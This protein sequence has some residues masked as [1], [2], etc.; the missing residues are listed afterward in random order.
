MHVQHRD[1]AQAAAVQD[2]GAQGEGFAADLGVLL[3][4]LVADGEVEAFDQ[5]MVEG[6]LAQEQGCVE[7]A[8]WDALPETGK[9]AVEPVLVD[10]ASGSQGSGVHVEGDLGQDLG[11]CG[12]G[13]RGWQVSSGRVDVGDTG[14]SVVSVACWHDFYCWCGC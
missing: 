14:V 9:E 1:H 4:E 5:V 13:S 11:G 3:F 2:R 7:S 6:K 10:E 8:A 12:P